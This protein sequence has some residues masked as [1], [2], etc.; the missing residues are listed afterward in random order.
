MKTLVLA[1][2]AFMAATVAY[3][4]SEYNI[5]SGDTLAVEVLEDP[6]L[7][8]SLLVLPNGTITFPF[9]GSV[10]A[11]G[12][13]PDA[14][15][16]SIA[17]GIASNFAATPTVFVTVQALRP[18]VESQGPQVGPTI[19]IF[20]LGEIGAPGQ[21]RIERGTTVLQ[22]LSTSGG[23]TRFAATKRILLRRSN[24]R[25]GEQTVSRIN[26][27]AIANGA[28]VGSDIVLADGDVIIVPERRLFE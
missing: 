19:D 20:M 10:Q 8:R 4:Q 22:A 16:G 27:N 12:R 5:R 24:P 18:L 9:A 23:F 17:A 3:A 21:K 11:G 26:Y 6:S 7:N 2:I 25:T 1:I 15:A 14:V 13:S 28:S